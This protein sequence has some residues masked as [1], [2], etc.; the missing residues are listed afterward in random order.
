MTSYR[1]AL[2][3]TAAF[4]NDKLYVLEKP[5]YL[6][7]LDEALNIVNISQINE[8]IDSH[9]FMSDG[10]IFYKNRVYLLQNI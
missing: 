2:A 6:V 7:Q 9:V 8:K 4:G 3:C 10:K 5:G 1:C